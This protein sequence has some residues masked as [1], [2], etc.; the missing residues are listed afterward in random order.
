MGVLQTCNFIKKRF[1]HRCFPVNI[2]KLLRTT[3]SKNI[4]KLFGYKKKSLK[5]Y[6]Q[7]SCFHAQNVLQICAE[8]L[9]SHCTKNHIFFFQTF[10]KHGLS[11]KNRTGIYFLYYQE[12][13]YFFFPKI[14]SYFRHKMKDDLS[15]KKKKKLEIWYFLQMFWKDGLSRKFVPEHNIYFFQKIWYFCFGRK[16]KEDDFIIKRVEIW[17]F[18]YIYVGVTSMTS[19]LPQQKDKDALV[20][21]KYT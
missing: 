18:L 8:Q 7:F 16:M 9:I 3:I 2:A 17:Y 19:P 11:K 21:K 4:W 15:Q 1:Q 20:P 14:W 5:C 13:R 6:H 10:W 12:R